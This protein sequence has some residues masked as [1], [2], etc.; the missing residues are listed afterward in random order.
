MNY[1]IKFSSMTTEVCEP[2]MRM[3]SVNTVW[4][5][6]R[7]HQ[8][9]YGTAK[10]LVKEDT[11]MKYYD[12]ARKLLYLETDVSGVGLG[13]QILQV[14][15]NVNCGFKEAPDNAMLPPITFASK[16]LSTAE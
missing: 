14:K 15:N 1:L 16:S 10:F 2:F 11:C 12:D 13:T 3:T 5:W 9:I 6:N 4:T 7:S 8:K